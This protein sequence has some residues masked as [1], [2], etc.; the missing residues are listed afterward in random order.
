M[1]KQILSHSPS[2]LSEH[3]KVQRSNSFKRM[4][5]DAVRNGE[6]DSRGDSLVAINEGLMESSNA[7]SVFD[8]S[9]S[10]L[11]CGKGQSK[12]KKSSVAVS[13]LTAET[14][15]YIPSRKSKSRN[16]E[17]K[18]KRVSHLQILT[19]DKNDSSEPSFCRK[20][21][22]IVLALVIVYI[23]FITGLGS[24]LLRQF[25]RIPSLD[26]EINEL[27]K[28]NARFEKQVDRLK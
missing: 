21:Q 27:K 11:E 23:V 20:H 18:K 25:F 2:S 13:A 10:D 3:K 12:S 24:Y 28:E 19:N 7:S 16:N 6:N 26:D 15:V 8:F 14:S 22:K 17:A 4:K 1:I 5:G 9:P